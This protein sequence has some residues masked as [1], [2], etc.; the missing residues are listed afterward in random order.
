MGAAAHSGKDAPA[1]GSCQLERARS[2]REQE[3]APGEE[4]GSPEGSSHGGSVRTG[5]GARR[6]QV[7]APLSSM[8]LPKRGDPPDGLG[9]HT[10]KSTLNR[11]LLGSILARLTRDNPSGC[12][13]PVHPAVLEHAFPVSR[14]RNITGLGISR[15]SDRYAA[16]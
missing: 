15:S 5:D 9:Q 6:A 8:V 3:V 1:L 2:G 12:M 13:L 16:H 10:V 7:T 14:R 11:R 4:R